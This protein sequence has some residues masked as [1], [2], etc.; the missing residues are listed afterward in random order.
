MNA[1]LPLAALAAVLLA[2]TAFAQPGP[3]PFPPPLPAPPTPLGNP[4][5]PDKVLLGKALFWEEQMSSSL[6][7]ACGTCHQPTA[8]GSDF[9]TSQ[10][11]VGSTHPGFDGLFGT[12]DDVRGSKGRIRTNSNDQYIASPEFGVDVQVTGRKTPTMINA[13]FSPRQFWDGR[14]GP[15][16]Q[17]PITGNTVLQA[18]AALESQAAGPPVSDAEMAH[19]GEDWVAVAARITNAV[20]LR[21]ATDI[22]ASLA[23]F[24]NNRTYPDLF[25]LA[26]GTS[27][28]TP[29]RIAMAL[30]AYERTLISNQSPFD[31][32]IAGVPG[33]LT[34]QQ[35]QGFAL[36]NSPQARCAV[37]HSGAL[38]SNNSFRNI[39]VRPNG[40][41]LG[42]GAITGNPADDGHF[43]VPN[44]RN[45]AI[46]GPYFHNGSFQ[47]LAEVVDFYDRGGDFH[48]GQDPAIAPLGLNPPQKASLIAFLNALT[49]PRVAAGT[50]PFDRPTLGTE[51]NRV[52][53]L[54]GPVSGGGP[55]GSP[56]AIAEEIPVLGATSFTIGVK[57]AAPGAFT[58]LALDLAPAAPP[59]A[60][61]GILLNL[62]ASPAFLTAPI[63]PTQ[64]SGPGGGFNSV[65]FKLPTTN[66]LPPGQS[67]YLQWILFGPG[68]PAATEGIAFQLFD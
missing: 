8:G 64:G 54:Y 4:T 32:A 31:L 5:T 23:T 47:T 42:R 18:N 14:A 3:P 11:P 45:V 35:V 12:P 63:G 28:V 30:A 21:L 52:P 62:A 10:D 61:S 2:A 22:P 20:P 51:T 1:R 26:F 27:E 49:D 66:P 19:V 56:R 53:E 59:I 65:S 40:E 6:T 60:V 57:N 67:V 50:A 43:K 41:D 7:V 48:V 36:F 37:C 15:A 34:Q 16:F 39:G 25:Q 58:L 29:T 55:A 33:S 68:G 38:T 46:R 13:A 9:R 44:L 24:I 17:D